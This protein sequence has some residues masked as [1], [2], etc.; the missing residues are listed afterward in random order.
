MKI[1]YD[2]QIFATQRYGGISRYIVEIAERASRQNDV[3]VSA[4]MHLNRYLG[5]STRLRRTG[6]RSEIEKAW[7]IRDKVNQAWTA[8]ASHRFQPD[9]VHETYY[10]AR[11]LHPGRAK[12]VVTIHDM[13]HELFPGEAADAAFHADLKKHALSR[14][15]AIV[16]VSETTR[17]DLL[18]I[19]PDAGQRRVRVI[20]HGH[21]YEPPSAASL[22]AIDA[23]TSSSPFILYVGKRGGY[24]RFAD[25]VT[26]HKLVQAQ[27]PGMKLVVFGA[28]PLSEDELAHIARTG[29]DR[30]DVLWTTGSDDLLNAAYKQARAFCYPSLYEGFGIPIL[31]A[32]AAGCPVVCCDTPVFREV[33]RDA[34]L[35][36]APQDAA[37]M[38]RQLLE[39]T[40]S[41]RRDTP[42]P[43]E[44]SWDASF[45][46]HL[47][48]YQELYEASR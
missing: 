46:Q 48:V 23:L 11:R 18:R 29:L 36:H 31:E 9:V 2:D 33:G 15:D 26:A 41:S 42:L 21:C 6:M 27:V 22:R 14:A 45:Q 17:Q 39:A 25:M 4:G 30:A 5:A 24:K 13:I 12:V 20:P 43:P 10:R 40:A 47:S 32:L 37:D 1:L 7:R 3:L 16:C 28:N 35:F 8:C 44:Y 19:Y 38:A 34:V